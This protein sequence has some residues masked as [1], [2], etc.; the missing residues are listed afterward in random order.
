[1]NTVV[2]EELTHE[3]DGCHGQLGNEHRTARLFTNPLVIIN[4]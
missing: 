1:M 4:Y 2:D 3:H